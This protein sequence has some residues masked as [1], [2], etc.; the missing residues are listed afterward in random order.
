[1]LFSGVTLAFPAFELEGFALLSALHTSWALAICFTAFALRKRRWGARW[2]VF[3]TLLTSV[4]YFFVMPSI[5]SILGMALNIAAFIL[6]LLSWN[7]TFQVISPK[8]NEP[9]SEVAA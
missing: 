2:W 7:L 1:M 3:F 4:F 8:A 6:V 9:E 5:I